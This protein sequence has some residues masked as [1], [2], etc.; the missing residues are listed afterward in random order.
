MEAT[1]TIDHV[2]AKGYLQR[3]RNIAARPSTIDGSL[4]VFVTMSTPEKS[5][6]FST[7]AKSILKHRCPTAAGAVGGGAVAAPPICDA[8]VSVAPEVLHHRARV[9]V[10][11][12]Q[13]NIALTRSSGSVGCC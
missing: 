10:R 3:H 13:L 6:I 1:L 5:R 12:V 9:M 4:T 8:V 7:A 2:Y 11:T